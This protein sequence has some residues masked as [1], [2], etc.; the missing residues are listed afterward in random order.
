[1]H[2]KTITLLYVHHSNF[3]MGGSVS[4]NMI[5]QCIFLVATLSDV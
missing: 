2:A 5:V 3:E 4:M 1:M